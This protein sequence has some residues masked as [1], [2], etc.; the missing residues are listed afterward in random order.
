MR[1]LLV[2]DPV[3]PGRT[4]RALA[5][6]R[7]LRRQLPQC[8]LTVVLDRARAA[9]GPLF[10]AAGVAVTGTEEPSAGQAPPAGARG[11]PGRPVHP[12]APA[13]PGFMDGE[14]VLARLAHCQESRPGL[15]V[16]VDD[17]PAALAAAI[18]GFPYALVTDRPDVP[19]S[20]LDGRAPA[21]GG[22][23]FDE[24]SRRR[25]S[26][27]ALFDWVARRAEVTVT[28]RPCEPASP[29]ALARPVSWPG[30]EES[31]E[32]TDTRTPAGI[33]LVRT[34]PI[35]Q[36]PAGAGAAAALRA[37][38]GLGQGPLM[39]GA[40][41]GAAVS[42]GSGQR[43]AERCVLAHRRLRR[44]HPGLRLLLLT[45]EAVEVPQDVVVHG[46]P[47]DRA[48]LLGEADFLV[49]APGWATATEAAVARVPTVLVH[50]G[51]GEHPQADEFDRLVRLGF[52]GLT[53]PTVD[54][55][56]DAAR[57]FVGGRTH[58]RLRGRPA[59]AAG[60]AEAAAHL[61]RAARSAPAARCRPA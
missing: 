49:A 13:A 1:I 51:P 31:K 2:P 17:V 27:R 8:A 24:G 25:D 48:A 18:G 4:V 5:L 39:A 19:P 37:R 6:A 42:G 16:C 32:G 59:A 9:F 60:T 23:L 50:G 45:T 55:I 47:P 43:L 46:F 38:L 7:E 22:V 53:A 29:T 14:R 36:E 54:G 15:V 40:T 11:E 44:H 56:T 21:A 52:P 41:D 30:T 61:A 57:P 10:G 28:D 35:V 3:E 20:R 34:G 33:R 58:T 12:G 26:L